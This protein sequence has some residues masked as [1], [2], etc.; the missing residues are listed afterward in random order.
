MYGNIGLQRY[1]EADFSSMTQEKMIV[2]LYEK[3][4]QDLQEAA[5]SLDNRVE[6]THKINHATRIISE[7]RGALDHS[8]GGEISGNLDAIYEYV[9]SECLQFLVD[10]DPRH[11]HDCIE[12]LEPLLDAWRQIPAGTGA[13]AAQDGKSPVPRSGGGPDPATI[14]Q[15]TDSPD[16]DC[17]GQD[18]VQDPKPQ[19]PGF[20]SV[21]A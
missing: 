4:I 7:L 1:K 13:R 3:V 6:M 9:F 10:Q 21:S 8:I 2:L 14:S 5:A 12:V 11:A 15:T 17:Q 20:L 16:P 19:T 18:G